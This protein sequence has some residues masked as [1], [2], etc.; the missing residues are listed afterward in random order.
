[1][2]A[3]FNELEEYQRTN[4]TR[5]HM[6]TLDR[7]SMSV[8]FWRHIDMVALSMFYDKSPHN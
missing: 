5:N 8:D 7:K 3:E 2:V 4:W 6:Y 1:M